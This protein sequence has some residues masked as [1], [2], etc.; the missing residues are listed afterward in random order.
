MGTSLDWAAGA[1]LTP[2]YCV[3]ALKRLTGEQYRSEIAIRQQ[4][5]HRCMVITRC[6]A[7]RSL[8]RTLGNATAAVTV[9]KNNPL[10]RRLQ[11]AHP[12]AV[13][14]DDIDNLLM[15]AFA[16]LGRHARS[17]AKQIGVTPDR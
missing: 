9:S 10:P 14:G 2:A 1:Q 3:R 16:G 8:Q 7:S 11:S 17:I 5:K 6:Y 12:P 4:Y 15:I 13:N